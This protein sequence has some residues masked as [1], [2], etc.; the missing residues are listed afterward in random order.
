MGNN[1]KDRGMERFAIGAFLI[2]VAGSCQGPDGDPLA[3]ALASKH[4]AIVRVMGNLEAH[5]VQIRYTRIHREGDSVRFVDYDFQVDP[6]RYFYP[7][8]TVKFPA[9]VAALVMLSG[10]EGLNRDS[11]FYVE[12]DSVETTFARSIV[13]IFA[14]SDNLANNRL[15]EFMG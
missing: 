14:V 6:E 3:R 9:A 5:E 15:L 8:S 2:L 13:E 11:R 7:A 12:G 10:M 4:P 1:R